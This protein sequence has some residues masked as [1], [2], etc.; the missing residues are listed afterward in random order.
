MLH[1]EHRFLL[2]RSMLFVPA[3]A[4]HLEVV[5]KVLPGRTEAAQLGAGS[6]GG[7]CGVTVQV[8]P[9]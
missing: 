5:Q 2:T 8:A 4:P 7:G 3:A 9:P 1:N 6:L